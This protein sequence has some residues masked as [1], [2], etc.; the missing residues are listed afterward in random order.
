M[1]STGTRP[2]TT[3]S[4]SHASSRFVH[5]L[6]SYAACGE[7]GTISRSHSPCA[8]SLSLSASHTRGPSSRSPQRGRH[9]RASSSKHSSPY[10]RPLESRYAEAA[11]TPTR[12]TRGGGKASSTD[13][14]ARRLRSAAI[15]GE[16]AAG[17]GS[18]SL[19]KRSNKRSTAALCAPSSPARSAWLRLRSASTRRKATASPSS[20]P[21][22]S[23][24]KLQ[25]GKTSGRRSSACSMRAGR[26][27]CRY[28]ARTTLR[29]PPRWRRRSALS[30]PCR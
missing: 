11:T 25:G 6:S 7:P 27:A 26:A 3:T 30:R 23:V 9:A 24:S 15:S 17:G 28:S 13:R 29:R 21:S 20:Q 10:E 4:A 2:I 5:A 19:S 14:A 8:G 22:S 1:P 12:T 16:S 18:G